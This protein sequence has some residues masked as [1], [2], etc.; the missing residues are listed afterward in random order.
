MAARP[1]PEGMTVLRLGQY[2]RTSLA[3]AGLLVHDGGH[4]P[5]W[6][7]LGHIWTSHKG[8]WWSLYYYVKFGCNWCSNLENMKVWIFHTF[9][10]KMPI[11][12]PQIRFFGG[13]WPLEWRAI[14]R[15]PQNGTSLRVNASFEPSSAKICP[16]VWPIGEFPKKEGINK[17]LLYFTYS[18]RSPSPI[19]GFAPNLVSGSCHR[20]LPV[21]IFLA[22][23]QGRSTLWGVESQWFP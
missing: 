7:C 8:A 12:A 22:I 9:G 10:L 23:G 16:S 18:F 21:I 20:Q 6:I 2:G 11:H 3:T 13:I 14:S 15:K 5:S 4:P 1:I 19:N 17:K